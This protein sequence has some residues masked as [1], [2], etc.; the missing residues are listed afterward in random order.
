MIAQIDKG[1]KVSDL[2]VGELVEIIEEIVERKIYEIGF[3]PDEGLEL[4]PEIIERLK[5][6][7]A[8][9]EKTIPHDEFWA[10]VERGE[11]V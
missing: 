9:E 2:T 4:K 6:S 10:K 7:F 5:K 11:D 3:D 1:R 8:G